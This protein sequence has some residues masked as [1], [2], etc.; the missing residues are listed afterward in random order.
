MSKE[1]GEPFPQD[2]I[3][4]YIDGWGWGIAADGRTICLGREAA[5]KE[6]LANPKLKSGAPDVDQIIDLERK[7]IA[8]VNLNGISGNIKTESSRGKRAV[9][10]GGIRTRPFVDIKYQPVN[11]RQLKA[12]KKLPGSE[13]QSTAPSL[14]S[15]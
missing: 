14:F 4:S 1:Q 12:R 2:T 6:A 10:T 11:T 3:I 8:E 15:E 5:V 7:I 9:R 13:A